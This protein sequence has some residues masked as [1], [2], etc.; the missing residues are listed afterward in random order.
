MSWLERKRETALV[1]GNT[2][3]EV[4]IPIPRQR[5]VETGAG[6]S[7]RSNQGITGVSLG[8]KRLLGCVCS[9]LR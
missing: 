6:T 4:R 9:A 1:A 3:R 8:Q 2:D 7:T 5:L